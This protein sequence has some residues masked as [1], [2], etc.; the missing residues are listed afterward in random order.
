MRE[1]A[2]A[3]RVRTGQVPRDTFDKRTSTSIVDQL[4][5]LE[6]TRK[7]GRL[8]LPDGDTLE[9]TNLHKVFWP[10]IKKTKGDLIRHYAKIA[11]FI[12]PVIDNRPLVM[13]RLPNGVDGHV[14]LPASRAGAG[15]AGRAHRDA[16]ATTTCRRGWSAAR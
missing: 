15:A 2:K 5:D 9:V 3:R 16:A 10:Q 13:K 8:T 4:D 1:G 14:V 11:P 6:K 7:N 12:L